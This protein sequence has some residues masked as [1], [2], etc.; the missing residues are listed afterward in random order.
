MEQKEAK[1]GRR[2]EIRGIQGPHCH[3]LCLCVCAYMLRTCA[4]SAS[5]QTEQ[6]K[7]IYYAHK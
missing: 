5:A 1:E 7:W 4:I 6:I 3:G 2:L